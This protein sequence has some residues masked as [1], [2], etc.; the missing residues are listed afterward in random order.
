MGEVAVALA[1]FTEEYEKF[2]RTVPASG[3]ARVTW[4]QSKKLTELFEHYAARLP[5]PV[6][7]PT[8]LDAAERLAERKEAA[9]ALQLCYGP[10]L[11]LALPKRAGAAGV[12]GSRR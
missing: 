12:V 10:V 1:A 3:T 6:R 8:W 9:L 11:G 4:K 2:L 7:A 5:E